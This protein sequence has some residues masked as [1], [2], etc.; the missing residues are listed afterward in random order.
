MPSTQD[1]SLSGKWRLVFTTDNIKGNR[2]N[3][4]DMHVGFT[5]YDD[6]TCIHVDGDNVKKTTYQIWVDSSYSNGKLTKYINL[7]SSCPIYEYEFTHDT[8]LLSPQ[9]LNRSM[10]EWYIR[11][12]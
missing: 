8:L 7:N 3:D 10:T 6:S 1:V 5:L 2:S 12:N 4:E 9:G 11:S